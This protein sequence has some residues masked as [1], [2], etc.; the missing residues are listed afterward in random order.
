MH[1]RSSGWTHL[2]A[3]GPV[4]EDTRVAMEVVWA[5]TSPNDGRFSPHE[6]VSTLEQIE[7]RFVELRARGQGL[8]GG[9]ASGQGLPLLTLGFRGEHAVVHAAHSPEAITLHRGNGAVPLDDV[10]EVLILNELARFS[11]DFVLTLQRAWRVL[12]AFIHSGSWGDP[13]DWRG[14]SNRS[15]GNAVTHEHEL[16]WRVPVAVRLWLGC[17][18]RPSVRRPS[19]LWRGSLPGRRER[20]ACSSVASASGG[21]GCVPTPMSRHVT[22]FLRCLL[23]P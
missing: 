2:R 14:L 22:P 18:V 3:R 8:P 12:N 17:R 15:R 11:G 4:S 19:G 5:A 23:R 6:L 20:R 10:V 9:S 1:L 13:R 7:R 16:R 21:D